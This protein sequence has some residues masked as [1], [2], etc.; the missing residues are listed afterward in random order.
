MTQPSSEVGDFSLGLIYPRCTVNEARNLEMPMGA[1]KNSPIHPALSSPRTI[2]GKKSW[3]T[4][5]F[6]TYT[7]QRIPASASLHVSPK[8]GGV[9]KY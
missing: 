1:S 6:Y 8:Q 3:I 2:K 7:H 4:A 9:E 5:A